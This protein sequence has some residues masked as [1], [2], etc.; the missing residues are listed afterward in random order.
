MITPIEFD[1]YGLRF[2]IYSL[3]PREAIPLHTHERE[4]SIVIVSGSVVL[5]TEMGE[6]AYGPGA[7]IYV[8]AGLSHA[9]RADEEPAVLMNITKIA[10]MER[11]RYL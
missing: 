8:K 6:H 3:A 9:L 10:D 5:S 4:H 1:A 11:K 2:S 7:P